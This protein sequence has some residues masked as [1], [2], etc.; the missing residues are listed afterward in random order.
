M[1]LDG[2]D[3]LGF[4]SDN[5]VGVVRA[6]GVVNSEWNG[7]GTSGDRVS[8]NKPFVDVKTGGARVKES[9]DFEGD[10][11]LWCFDQ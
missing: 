10:V 4:V 8:F 3:E 9:I 11:G 1:T 5:S 2:E 7:K 6:I